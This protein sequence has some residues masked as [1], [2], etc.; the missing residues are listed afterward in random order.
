ML[1]DESPGIATWWMLRANIVLQVGGTDEDVES[2]EI[3]FRCMKGERDG[4]EK[5]IWARFLGVVRRGSALYYWGELEVRETE[6]RKGGG[7]KLGEEEFMH[8]MLCR[9]KSVKYDARPLIAP[10]SI[11]HTDSASTYMQLHRKLGHDR[12]KRPRPESPGG[13]GAA[14]SGAWER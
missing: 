10:C 7:G 4:K 1:M 3:S 13:G 5:A 11:V 14:G 6:A 8:H 9:A 12:Y 2:D